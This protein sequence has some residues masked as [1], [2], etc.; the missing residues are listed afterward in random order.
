MAKR[1]RTAKP[2]LS[3]VEIFRQPDCILPKSF[4]EGR[5]IPNFHPESL[6]YEQWWEEQVRRCNE[7]WSDGGFSVTP[8]Y[9]YHLNLKKINMLDIKT[10]IPGWHHPY[11]SYEDQQLFNDFAE[12]KR[13][14]EGFFLITGRGFGKS[15]N[16]ATLVE[17]KF[18]FQ[19]TS[20]VMVTASTDK[21][22]NL[23]WEKI[24]MGLNSQPEEI[25]RSMK[26]DTSALK[27][28][29]YEEKE[30]GTNRF[31]WYDETAFIRKV[32]Y[33]SDPE[34]T[35]G[36]RPDIHVWEEVGSWTG[37]ASLIDCYKKTE[38][39][40]W[41]GGIKTTFPIFIG[42]GGA[43]D[44]GGSV[45]AKMMFTAPE[46]F[47][48]K[49]YVY[50]DEKIGKFIPAYKKFTSFYEKSGESDEVKA[51]E[52]LDNRRAKKKKNPDLYRQETSEF[53]FNPMEAFQTN[54]AGI[55]PID[56]LEK[57]YA[58]I[59]RN[60]AL[61]KLV[62]RG[63]LDWVHEGSKI[64]GVKWS[65]VAEGDPWTFEIA[66]HPAWT[67]PDWKNGMNRDMYISGCDSFD[68]AAEDSITKGKSPGSII[69]Y[70]R[71]YD[72]TVPSR[73]FVAKCTQRTED[74]TEF[75]WNTVKLNLYY[76]CRM[77]AEYT[78]VGIFQHYI[79]KG[80]EHMLYKRP[81]LD[82]TVLKES[83]STNTYG[84]AMPEQVKR[85]VIFNLK[86]F[87]LEPGTVDQFYFQ[88]LIR[89]MLSFSFEGRDK[90][91]H[92]ETM[93]AA[94]ALMGDLDM[95]KIA[96]KKEETSGVSWPKFRRNASGGLVFD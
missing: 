11:F 59:E 60:P 39:S 40:W 3:G 51:K 93:A 74:A 12:A 28:S 6:D 70:K 84:L 73:F 7:G 30:P 64:V 66:E 27:Q 22:A 32:V 94:L 8:E 86:S 54:G 56:I 31:K 58:E 92:D 34:K 68:A 42:T 69:V 79:T 29:G 87:T 90:N 17:H 14:G 46:E 21:F 61:K 53:P 41:R 85:H 2:T 50:E 76:N 5:F 45:D 24:A 4:F 1:F 49:A 88:S 19:D 62:Q 63:N 15:F 95:Y 9:Y 83:I 36:T 52:F 75:Y 20:E 82:K 35:R 23:L 48:I 25:R 13:D 55:F 33:D 72:I 18:T 26:V 67:K 38:P 78:K 47:G 81:K 96:A 65:P 10:L 37:A 57:R 77:L 91:K 44:T 16:V 43:M 89:D 71:F 80:F